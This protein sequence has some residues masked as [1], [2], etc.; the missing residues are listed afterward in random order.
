[1][2]LLA[3]ICQVGVVADVELDGVD[4]EVVAGDVE[5]VTGLDGARPVLAV[6]RIQNYSSAVWMGGTGSAV[7]YTMILTI[8]PGVVE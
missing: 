6:P 2:T 4:A 3:S 8:P 7:G 1:M 5:L